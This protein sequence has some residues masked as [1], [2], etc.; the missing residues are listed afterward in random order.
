[1]KDI[2]PTEEQTLFRNS[3]RS[4]VE[5]EVI[6]AAQELDEKG[7]FPRELFQRCAVNGY[8]GLRYPESAGGMTRI[9]SPTA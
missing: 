3:V 7:E 4:F 8:F 6:P 2:S 1:M 5:R 9:L